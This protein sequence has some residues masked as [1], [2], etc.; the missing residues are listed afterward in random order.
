MTHIPCPVCGLLGRCEHS[1]EREDAEASH[2]RQSMSDFLADHGTHYIGQWTGRKPVRYRCSRGHEWD[3]S[4][5]GAVGG[6]VC[7]QGVGFNVQVCAHC[8][9]ERLTELCG[10]VT[11]VDDPEPD[12]EVLS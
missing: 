10:S 12:I 6:L 3:D 8:L 9:A 7:F 2:L 5:F 1:G 11:K 4:G